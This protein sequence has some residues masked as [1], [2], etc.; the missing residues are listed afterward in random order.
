[1][2]AISFSQRHMRALAATA[3]MFLPL[4]IAGGAQAQSADSQAGANAATPAPADTASPADQNQ[5]EIVVTGSRITR[6]PITDQPV[7]TLSSEL[8]QQRGFTNVGQ[9]L[10]QLPGFGAPG[11]SVAGSQ[12]SFGAGQTFANLYNLGSQRTLTLVNGMRFVSPAT[13]SIFGAVAGS[14]VDLGQ[15]A[16]SL[17]DHIEVVSV[18]GAPIYGSDAIAGTVNV[19]LKKNYDGFEATG[20]YGL[21][22]YGDG[23]DYNASLLAGKNFAEGRGNITANFYYDHQNGITGADRS[24]TYGGSSPFFGTAL[25]D[26]SYANQLYKGG[27][28]YNVFTN[29][30]MPM[31]DDYYAVLGQK[32]AAGITDALGRTLVFNKAGQLVPFKNGN[33]T[34]SA[35]Y[36]AGG[37]GFAIGDYSNFLVA[38]ERYQ[39]TLLAHY[40]IS[41]SIRFNGEVWFSRNYATNT[42]DQPFYN[43][44]G[45]GDAGDANGNLIINTANPYL[46]AADRATIVS[47]LTAAGADP[48][49]FYM[50][51]ANTDLSTGSFRTSSDLLRFVAGVTGDIQA[52]ERKFTWEINGTYGRTIA[53]TTSREIVTQNFFNAIDA[54]TDA[55]GNIIC[56]P[57]Y[58]N[59]AIATGSATCAP[60][61]IFGNGNASKAAQDYIT[62]LATTRQIN[63]QSDIIADI[64]GDLIKLPGGFAKFVL[65]YEHRYE[66]ASFDPGAFY[67]GQ[68][69]GDGTR[70]QYGN[71]IPIDP[72]AGSY[73][74]NEGFGELSLPFI[75]PDN[76][77]PAVYRLE[78][79]AAGRY[80]KNS[81]AGGFWTYTGGATYAP[82]KD[83][84]LRG[85]YTR[86]FR[87]PAITELFAPIGS[88][89]DT[90]NDPCDK[91]YIGQGP[92]PARRAANCAAAG[93]PENFTSVV[94]DA[95]VQGTSGGNPKLQ[96]EVANSWTVGG[97]L[98]PSF[99]PGLTITSDYV[100]I[101]IKNEIASLSLT[102]LMNACYDSASGSSPYCSSFTR[103][104]DS[105][106]TGFAEGNYN[107]GQEVFRALQTS[108]RWNLP[109]SRFGLPASA[110]QLMFDV[111]YL[112]TFRHYYQIGEGDF[113]KTAGSIGEPTDNFTAT[114]TYS[115]PTFNWMWQATYYGP[116]KVAVNAAD[117]VYQYPRVGAYVLFNTAMGFN[118]NDRFSLR[119]NVNNVFNRS[120]PFPYYL[121]ATGSTTRYFD[122]IM[123][124]YMRITAGVKF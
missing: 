48:S 31:V 3:A 19:L 100:N 52:G 29:T 86:S 54:T 35:L 114:A 73:N 30:G 97:V 117:T 10:Q 63:K 74:T 59:A 90:A 121:G 4:V 123:G 101:K 87:A 77:V 88:V 106:V 57:G 65:G 111:N 66:S 39:G 112:H 108:A 6:A 45:F 22:K 124:R 56:R 16:P 93:V 43:Y 84:T 68:D 38:S 109:L 21:S 81:I 89:F 28:H 95:T 37:D 32:A 58:T 20:S 2:A 85:N 55:N 53:R 76:A 94:A 47:N 113:T 78:V 8:I 18:G 15:I 115:K 64:K 23:Q 69:N 103:G 25:G 102:D 62:A 9:A 26:A 92:N 27:R 61:N 83:L 107:I 72:V 36:Q 96:N 5:S 33:P 79:N 119:L 60:L 75:S 50:A 40:D 44:Y 24:N 51:R 91:R 118:V 70:T 7:A 49:R 17:V 42:A 110:G 104:T 122:A 1:M 12:G 11:N 46:S 34:G 13:T 14:P 116:A 41:D 71:S 99:L 67:Y 120:V 82:V 105:Q 98:L 80:V